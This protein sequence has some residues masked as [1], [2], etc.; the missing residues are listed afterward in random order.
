MSSL[1]GKEKWEEKIIEES[2]Y[3]IDVM[4]EKDGNQSLACWILQKQIQ[5]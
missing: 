3:L 5:T 1:K 4:Q 2:Q